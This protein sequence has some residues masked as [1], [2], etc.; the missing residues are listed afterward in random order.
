VDNQGATKF[1]VV[2][3]GGSAGALDPL[4]K[5]AGAFPS[6]FPAAVFITTHVPA[7]SV[8]ALPH[9]LNRASTLFA[10]HAIE[11]APIAPG[12]I[13]VAPPNRHLILQAGVMRVLDGPPENNHRPSIDVLFRSASISFGSG[14]C[15]VLLSGTLDDGVAGLVSIHEAG[16]VAFVQDPEDARYAGMPSNAIKTGAVDGIFS[17]ER[18]VEAI[19]HWASRPLSAAPSG[20]TPREEHDS[21]TPSV[22]R[23][24]DCGGLFGEAMLSAREQHL[25]SALRTSIRALEERC[26]LLKRLAARSCR[27]GETAIGRRLAQ[28]VAEVEGDIQRVSSVLAALSGEGSNPA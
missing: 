5:I 28:R 12:R 9:L 7:T 17:P 10:T 14:A 16:G 18:L 3:I 15:G 8:S 20:V 25:E 1:P 13:I 24:A 22:F 11:G 4:L 6:D 19:E 27:S 21:G 23:C 26:D 2:C